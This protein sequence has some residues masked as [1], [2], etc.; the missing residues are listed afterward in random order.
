MLTMSFTLFAVLMF[1]AVSFGASLMFV[2]I[3]TLV[4]R[5]ADRNDARKAAHRKH[6]MEIDEDREA[7]LMAISNAHV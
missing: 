2:L 1:L 6:R 5:D 3:L 7:I 4:S